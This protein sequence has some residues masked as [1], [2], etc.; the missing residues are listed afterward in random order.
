MADAEPLAP[1]ADPPEVAAGTP[2]R[3]QSARPLPSRA[4][5]SAGSLL[6][7][8]GA[9]ALAAALLRSPSLPSPG[10]VL[11]LAV[12]E[13]LSGELPTALSATLI[14][15][16]VAFLIGLL[17]GTALG[18]LMGRRRLLDALLDAPLLVLLNVPALVIAILAYVWIGLGETAAILAVVLTKLPN[19]AV[20]V[21]E[22]ARTLDPKLE[23]IGQVYHLPRTVRFRGILLPQLLP[24]I[25]AAARTGLALVWKIVLVVEL[26]GRPNGVGF[27]LGLRFQL[28]DVAGL[29][30][31]ALSFT[32]LML[33]IELLILQPIEVKARRWRL[34]TA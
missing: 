33:V 31:Y 1:L 26:L 17:A 9:W 2:R 34:G 18:L 10:A 12:R 32:A 5:L 29:L 20:I 22:G 7:L 19:V 28:F 14:R 15:V 21:R 23:E 11:A 8:I 16:A 30:A 3:R 24:Y 25:A 6:V 4:V 27:E 13:T